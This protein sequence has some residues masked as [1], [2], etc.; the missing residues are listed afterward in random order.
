MAQAELR[1]TR[2]RRQAQKPDYVY[3]QSEV[4]YSY[5]G[6]FLHRPNSLFSR[7]NISR[8]R[9]TMRTLKITRNLRRER[10]GEEGQRPPQRGDQHGRLYYM[11]AESEKDRLNQ[12]WVHGKESAGHRDLVSMI[13]LNLN[14]LRRG[15]GQ[16]RA[17]PVSG[18]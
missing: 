4:R 7:M 3:Y 10:N 5:L 14:D 17:Q 12:V 13:R 15:P 6:N 2:T 9:G 11:P 8:K 16:K 1:E 18:L